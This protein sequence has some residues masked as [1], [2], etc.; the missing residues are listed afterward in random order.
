MNSLGKTAKSIRIHILEMIY[1]AK[2]SHIASCFSAVDILNILYAKILEIDPKYPS[3]PNRDYLI[4]SKGHAAAA[5]YSTLAHYNFFP[6]DELFKYCKNGS[7]F[8]GH[9]TTAVP[10]VEFSTGALGHGLS[11]AC[12][13]ALAS[14]KRVYVIIS[15]G[16]CDEGSIWEAA[17]FAPYHHLHNLTLIIDYNKIQSF[18][19][20]NDVLSLEPLVSKWKSFNWQVLEVDGHNYDN[21]ERALTCESVLPTVIIAHTV[22]GKGV[23]F[24]EN[25]LV[26]HYRTP[27]AKQY[28]QARKELLI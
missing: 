25:D 13:L 24:M 9:V 27:D 18:G 3:N 17:L 4:M 22:K 23:S 7:Q 1:K 2:S 28:E 10:G 21:L 8:A 26:W 19:R 11:V 6:I 5:L 15:D 16:E 12:G 14:K 20:V